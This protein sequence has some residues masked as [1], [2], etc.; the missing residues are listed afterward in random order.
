MTE[1][2]SAGTALAVPASSDELASHPEQWRIMRSFTHTIHNASG[3]PVVVTLSPGGDKVP[4]D[5][6]AD[7][8]KAYARNG[9]IA[10]KEG[11]NPFA[12]QKVLSEPDH[13]LNG[14]DTQVFSRLHEHPPSPELLER[15]MRVAE[16]RHRS[17]VLRIALHIM[18]ERDRRSVKAI[19]S[20]LEKADPCSAS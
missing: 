8:I 15:I 6:T 10:P 12:R 18:V 19:E 7:D 20:V 5:L 13:Y 1:E 9:W 3:L 11:A 14:S 16:D 4:E 2:T 17:P